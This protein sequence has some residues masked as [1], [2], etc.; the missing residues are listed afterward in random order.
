MLGFPELLE[1]VV[2]LAAE[3]R[4]RLRV[5]AEVQHVPL[6]GAMS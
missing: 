4:D 6:L 1:E 5:F 2:G 3:I